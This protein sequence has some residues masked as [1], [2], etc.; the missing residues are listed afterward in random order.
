MN[1][2]E[3]KTLKLDLAN[4]DHV[5]GHNFDE[6]VPVRPTLLMVRANGVQSFM[7][8]VHLETKISRYRLKMAFD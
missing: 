5:F 4:I 1:G 3:G 7:D 6:P 8:S 2:I